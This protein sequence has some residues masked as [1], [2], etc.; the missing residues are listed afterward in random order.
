MDN[1]LH[2]GDFTEETLDALGVK[3]SVLHL[4]AKQLR[5]LQLNT[6]FP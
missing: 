4:T 2:L 3:Y 1:N 6:L 5:A